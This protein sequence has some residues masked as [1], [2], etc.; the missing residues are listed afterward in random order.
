[1]ENIMMQL[2]SDMQ[3]QNSQTI[4]KLSAQ[5]IN[6]YL[7][8]SLPDWQFDNINNIIFRKFEFK[9]F[10][11]TIFFINAVAFICEKECHHPDAKFGFNYC[12]IAFSTHDVD[13]ISIN[14]MICAAKIDKL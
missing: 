8:N 5:D 4:K 13:G 7:T 11:Q 10:K 9:N 3:C 14:D 12:E 1:M 2:L 6:E